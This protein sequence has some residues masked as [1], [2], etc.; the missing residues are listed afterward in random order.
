MLT[1]TEIQSRINELTRQK[2]SYEK[3]MSS[4]KTSLTYA[5]KLITNLEDSLNILNSSNDYLKRYFTINNKTVDGGKIETN[6]MK[7]NQIIRNIKNIIIPSI[8]SNVR[9][10]TTK[11]NSITREI[12]N[13]KRQINLVGNNQKMTLR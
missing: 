5:N 7:I 1:N 4:Y 3:T 6:K 10:L 2:S 8:N 12:N 13:L 11:I 9:D